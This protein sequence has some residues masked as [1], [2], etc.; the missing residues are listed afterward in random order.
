MSLISIDDFEHFVEEFPEMEKFYTFTDACEQLY[1]D[2][3]E[4]IADSD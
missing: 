3:V 4:C 2:G 1:I